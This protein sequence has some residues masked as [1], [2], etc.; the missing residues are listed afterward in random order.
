MPSLSD[1]SLARLANTR[2]TR[3]TFTTRRNDE[4]KARI[5]NSSVV[6]KTKER[7]VKNLV[8]VLMSVYFSSGDGSPATK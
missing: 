3:Q 7:E 4:H 1:S 8:F 5:M 6:G 2:R